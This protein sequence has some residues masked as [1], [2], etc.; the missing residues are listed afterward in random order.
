MSERDCNKQVERR[1]KINKSTLIVGMDIGSEFNAMALMNEAGEVLG[2]YPKIY[3]S[4]AGFE[5]FTKEIDKI[6]KR[7]GLKERSSLVL[8][9]GCVLLRC[10]WLAI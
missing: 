2:R 4:R 1:Q 5:Y 7:A 10:S 8:M 9:G 3:N 6:K